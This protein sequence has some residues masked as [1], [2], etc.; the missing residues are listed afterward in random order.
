[1]LIE[2]G[3]PTRSVFYWDFK[4]HDREGG[5]TRIGFV[6]DD[7]YNFINHLKPFDE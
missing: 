7:M 3:L 2:F 1:M 4:E 5:A 6:A